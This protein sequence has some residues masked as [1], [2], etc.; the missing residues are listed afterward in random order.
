M[1]DRLPNLRK[2]FLQLSKM[3]LIPSVVSERSIL[4]YIFPTVKG[5]KGQ[6]F[7]NITS[8]AMVE[9]KQDVIGLEERKSQT[10]DRYYD[11]YSMLMHIPLFVS[12]LLPV[13]DSLQYTYGTLEE[14]F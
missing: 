12:M 14:A 1:N 8:L 13:Q 5:C 9:K 6:D 7:S 10:I 3:I 11:I 2:V 4:Q